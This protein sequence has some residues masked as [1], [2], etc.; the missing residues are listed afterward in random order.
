MNSR[1]LLLTLSGAI[2]LV[3][4]TSPQPDDTQPTDTSKGVYL[5]A[6]QAFS[7]EQCES[8]LD[9][10]EGV[11]YPKVGFLWGTFGTSTAC[12]RRFIERFH[13]V[14]KRLKVVLFNETC[15]RAPRYCEAQRE[16][17]PDA[18]IEELNRLLERNEPWVR[19]VISDRIAEAQAALIGVVDEY[20]S[21]EYMTALEHNFSE[22]AAENHTAIVRG[23][24]RDVRIVINPVAHSL[25]NR[26][27]GSDAIEL[28]G[29]QAQFAPGLPC[30]WSNDGTDIDFGR[31]SR[32]G[33]VQPWHVVRDRAREYQLRGC[34]VWIW[35]NSQG[36]TEHFIPPSEREFE[37][38]DQAIGAVSAWL[39]E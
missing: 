15:R 20:T 32:L 11:S 1:L 35:W 10:F 38:D 4:C 18:A 14:H 5:F 8:A 16:I 17:F 39:L 19:E 31:G 22:R 2:L 6:L 21:V 29:L 23:E 28:H 27:F 33:E 34:D 36:I 13:G 9:V 37:V 25:G 30:S 3:A 12:I 24:V 26:S 7:Q